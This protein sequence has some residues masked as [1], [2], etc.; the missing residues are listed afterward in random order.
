MSSEHLAT[1]IGMSLWFGTKIQI[2]RD[3]ATKDGQ[4]DMLLD[5]NI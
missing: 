2:F 3:D 1:Y 4:L 5:Y